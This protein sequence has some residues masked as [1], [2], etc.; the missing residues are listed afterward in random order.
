MISYLKRLI[1]GI[2]FKLGLVWR[3]EAVS[4]ARRGRHHDAQWRYARAAG[5]VPD[6]DESWL[7][8]EPASGAGDGKQTQ[9]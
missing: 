3:Q 1:L 7:R 4:L 9:V 2:R 6:S 5:L 8:L